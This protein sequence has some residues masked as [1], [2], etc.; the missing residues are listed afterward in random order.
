MKKRSAG[1]YLETQRRQPRQGYRRALEIYC[2]WSFGYRAVSVWLGAAA[3]PSRGRGSSTAG[4]G[5]LNDP[6][7][8][9]GVYATSHGVVKSISKSALMVAM[10]DEHEMKFRITRKAKFISSDKE[11][12]STS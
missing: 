9:K 10:D 5:A 4:R 3:G 11:T 12:K 6:N 2:G 1:A 7:S 8:P